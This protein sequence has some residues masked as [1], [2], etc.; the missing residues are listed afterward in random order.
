MVSHKT[1]DVLLR[2]K[3]QSK[4]R[5]ISEVAKIGQGVITDSILYQNKTLVVLLLYD[6]KLMLPNLN[7]FSL[8]V[9][10]F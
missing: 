2:I 7:F 10:I 8:K 3:F 1:N 6:I 9:H 5:S 4:A